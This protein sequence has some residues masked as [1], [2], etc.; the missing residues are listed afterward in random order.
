MKVK[1]FNSI[2]EVH[3]I[4]NDE[5]WIRYNEIKS[6][7]P[8]GVCLTEE[9]EEKLFPSMP[10][11]IVINNTVYKPDVSEHLER[12]GRKVDSCSFYRVELNPVTDPNII[13]SIINTPEKMT[14]QLRERLEKKYPTLT[15]LGLRFE[16]KLNFIHKASEIQ[17]VREDGKI[18][19]LQWNYSSTEAEMDKWLY[20]ASKSFEFMNQVNHL[21]N[22]ESISITD[23][24]QY[25]STYWS[26]KGVYNN[27]STKYSFELRKYTNYTQLYIYSTHNNG[28][29]TLIELNDHIS[30][31]CTSNDFIT[32]MV[33]NCQKITLDTPLLENLRNMV[34]E[35]KPIEEMIC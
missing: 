21:I 5:T 7:L 27:D 25:Y 26:V 29:T 30:I 23:E 24:L 11:Y 15:E 10:D 20:E 33:E 9:Q 1:T 14:E 18:L 2:E 31:T 6:A 19:A 32:S 22:E 8:S 35:L 34:D 3:K 28:T 17:L 4:W 12:Y 16:I 13:D